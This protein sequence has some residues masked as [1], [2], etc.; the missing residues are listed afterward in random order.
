MRRGYAR[1]GVGKLEEAGATFRRAIQVAGESPE[2]WLF[3]RELAVTRAMMGQKAEAETA[4]AQAW[5]RAPPGEQPGASDAFRPAGS[6][7]S[8][9]DGCGARVSQGKCL[10]ENVP[11]PPP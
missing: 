1:R 8:S 9:V 6:L 11:V 3:Y 10:C 5:R 2:G 7:S 4:A